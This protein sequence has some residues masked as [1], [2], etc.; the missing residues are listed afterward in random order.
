MPNAPREV[1]HEDERQDECAEKKRRQYLPEY[2]DDRDGND[3]GRIGKAFGGVFGEAAPDLRGVGIHA[4]GCVG[5]DV[6]EIGAIAGLAEELRQAEAVVHGAADL[7]CGL[8][9]RSSGRRV[10]SGTGR[11]RRRMTGRCRGASG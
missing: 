2:E 7:G 10:P 11:S 3:A 5:G 1:T 9:R 6:G 4:A 8:R